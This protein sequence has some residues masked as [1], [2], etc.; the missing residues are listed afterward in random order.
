MEGENGA[1]AV[2]NVRFLSPEK[3]MGGQSFASASEFD[4]GITKRDSEMSLNFANKYGSFAQSMDHNYGV[5]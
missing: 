1:F 3:V 2:G 4:G 5:E